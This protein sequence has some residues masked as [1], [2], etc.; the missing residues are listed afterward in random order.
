MGKPNIPINFEEA[1]GYETISTDPL[2]YEGKS[3]LILGIFSKYSFLIFYWCFSI[4]NEVFHLLLEG[5]GNAA[6]ETA[7][8]IYSSAN[9]VHMIS[10]SRIRNAFATHYVGDVRLNSVR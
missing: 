1:E 2:D 9:F 6:F 7:Q 10:R 5:R 3:V 4:L 8:S